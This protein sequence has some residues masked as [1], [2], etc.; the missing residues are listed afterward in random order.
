[1]NLGTV[2]REVCATPASLSITVTGDV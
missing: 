1:V 2:W